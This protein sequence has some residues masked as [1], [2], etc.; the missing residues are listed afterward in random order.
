MVKESCTLQDFHHALRARDPLGI[1][2]DSS[3][4]LLLH[5]IWQLLTFDPNERITAE[6]ALSHP[7]F[8]SPDGTLDSLYEIPGNHN[9]LISG[10]TRCAH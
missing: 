9:A 4:D 2:F 3:T 7:F 10:N 1:G 8:T 6:E 5:L